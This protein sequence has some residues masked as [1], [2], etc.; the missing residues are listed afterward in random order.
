MVVV[1]ARR[2][3]WSFSFSTNL[4]GRV[5]IGFA[6]LINL[7]RFEQFPA[8]IAYAKEGSEVEAMVKCA[9]LHGFKAVPRS[10]GHQ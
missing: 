4:R 9:S 2:V 6:I 5:V 1:L 10:G 3:C 7:D 8:V